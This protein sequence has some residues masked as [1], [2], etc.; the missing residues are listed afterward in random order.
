MQQLSKVEIGRMRQLADYLETVPVNRFDLKE[1]EVEKYEP[2]KTFL[3]GLIEIEPECGFVGCAMGWAA[4][5]KLFAGLRIDEDGVL[6]YKG[7]AHFK[8]AAKVLGISKKNA[9]FLFAHEWYDKY[10]SAP[11]DVA[12]RLRRFA[13]R[14]ESRIKRQTL[15]EVRT[16]KLAL[17]G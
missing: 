8:A 16:P 7:F 6:E 1:W 10:H 3:F 17:V 4:H 15:K 9:E 13:D 2:A 5:S 12:A 14:V 11:G